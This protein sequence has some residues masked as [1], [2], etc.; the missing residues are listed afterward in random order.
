M[1]LTI[2]EFYE[3][4]EQPLELE[5][6][7]GE[8][9][10][11]RIIPEPSMNRPGLVLAGFY[12]YFAHKRIQVL[13]LAELTYLRSLTPE[14]R[15]SRV[16]NLFQKDIPALVVTRYRHA[17]EEVLTLSAKAG[18]SVM[19]TRMITMD[20]I[21]SGTVI[22]DELTSPRGRIHG[23]MVD[24]MGVGVLIQGAPGIGKSETAL[25]LIERGHSLVADDVTVLNRERS[26]VIMCS[27]VD[28]TR[29]HMEIRGLGLIHVPSLF[30]VASMRV[31]MKLDL[32][33]HLTAQ[34]G[35]EGI[36][37]TGLTPQSQEVLGVDIPM[38]NL[39][40]AAG[41]DSSLLIE[42]AALNQK[43][44]LLGHDAAK[45]L[46]DKIIGLLHRQRSNG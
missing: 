18:V 39:P 33:V 2:R 11:D 20:F 41:R 28:L 7:C 42:A 25:A 9:H 19:R 31:R 1:A 27:A 16:R 17:P 36:D 23:T 30:G 6:I 10:L 38:V 37:R 3:A 29:Y 43:L 4:A 13:G 15:H 21:N 12:Q 35:D 34:E 26:G 45:E 44:K 14:E 40:V 32:I 22:L 46:D 5:L 24:I 8:E